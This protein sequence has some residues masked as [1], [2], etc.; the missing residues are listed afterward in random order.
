M[1]HYI[2]ILGKK[3]S[4]L[5]DIPYTKYD[6]LDQYFLKNRD[7][8]SMFPKTRKPGCL[9]LLITCEIIN[10]KAFYKIFI[11]YSSFSLVNS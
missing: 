6:F 7:Q 3:I 1:E 4:V 11:N 2:E 8:N 5:V 9:V 10:D